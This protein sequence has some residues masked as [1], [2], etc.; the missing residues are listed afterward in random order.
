M[1]SKGKPY[2]YVRMYVIYAPGSHGEDAVEI[3]MGQAPLVLLVG[4]GR[5][6][7]TVRIVGDG[8]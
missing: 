7:A 6:R 4:G 8:G 3:E 2:M 5:Y 1:L